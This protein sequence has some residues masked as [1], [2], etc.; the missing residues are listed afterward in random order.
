MSINV[1]VLSRTA[2]EAALGA[3]RA[4]A[5]DVEAYLQQRSEVFAQGIA[6]L[7]KDRAA[8]K[9]DDDDLRFAWD[10]IVKSEET[11]RKAIRVTAKVALQNAINAAIAVIKGAANQAIGFKIL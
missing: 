9:I 3:A 4:H 7:V 1:Q 11:A 2:L 8:K 5:Q 10:Q 6:E